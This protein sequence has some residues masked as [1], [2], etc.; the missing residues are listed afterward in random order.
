MAPPFYDIILK[1][2]IMNEIISLLVNS[3]NVN[4]VYEIINQKNTPP[5]YDIILKSNIMNEIINLI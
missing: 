2:N 5:F 4:K 1:S 3:Q